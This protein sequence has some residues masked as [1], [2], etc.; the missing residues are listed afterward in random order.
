MKSTNSLGLGHS[1]GTSTIKIC[2][3][4]AVLYVDPS[5]DA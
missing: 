2:L 5:N 3:Q 1:H 4:V